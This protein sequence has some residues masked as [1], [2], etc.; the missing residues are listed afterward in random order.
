MLIRFGTANYLSISDYTEISFI[1]SNSL[2]DNQASLI[3]LSEKIQLLPA[4]LV[5]G[6]NASG[7]TTI[8]TA[9]Q[10]LQK[11]VL[12]SAT[13]L[14]PG[15]PI[16]RAPFLLAP[17]SKEQLTRHDCD[18]I[19]DGI[20][21]HYGF[22]YTREKYHTEWLYA[23]PEGQPRL[24]FSRDE[25]GFTFGRHLKG[26]NRV[27]ESMTRFNA[28]FLSTAA[29]NAHPYLTSLYEY[30]RD[31]IDFIGCSTSHDDV[32]RALP[33]TGNLDPR[34]VDF[35]QIADTGIHSSE[36][37]KRRATEASKKVAQQLYDALSSVLPPEVAL[38]AMS[39]ERRELRLG[40]VGREIDQL[41][42]L[43]LHRESR[44]TIRL[45]A[46][47]IK[48]LKTLDNGG[49]LILDELDSSLHT[50]LAREFLRMFN[51]QN[52]PRAQ[53]IASTHDTNLL[54]NDLVRR[55]QVWLAE[56]SAWGETSIIPLTD[57]RIRKEDNLERLYLQ[58]RFG[59]LPTAPLDAMI[60]DREID[61]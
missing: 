47:L 29:Q 42:Y 58:G 38:Q 49:V 57:T 15:Q 44:G 25:H 48:A 55:D 3:P 34:I 30:F 36:I 43:P 60:L 5:Y 11:H 56:K 31:K 18:I 40:H 8:L 20:R 10:N 33:E 52:S 61:G 22:E 23:Y 35:L 53:I 13:G 27:I 37:K 17:D 9:L 54:S 4:L 12:E 7:K 21:H 41:V 1:A 26:H 59:A 24:L 6:A 16:P 45:V 46:L 50:V 2:K 19:V 32:Q 51:R 14:Q 28:L 39:D